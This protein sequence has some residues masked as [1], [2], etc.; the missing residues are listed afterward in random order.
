MPPPPMNQTDVNASTNVN[1]SNDDIN[2]DIL[3]YDIPVLERQIAYM[4]YHDDVIVPEE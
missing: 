3:P 4:N 1:I 2:L